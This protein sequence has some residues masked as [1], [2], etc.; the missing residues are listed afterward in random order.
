MQPH[1]AEDIGHYISILQSRKKYF[2][3]PALVVVVH[4]NTGGLTVAFHL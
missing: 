4:G 3:I 1:E 2:V